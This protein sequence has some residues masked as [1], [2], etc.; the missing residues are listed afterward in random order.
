MSTPIFQDGYP[1]SNILPISLKYLSKGDFV[2]K[3][4]PFYTLKSLNLYLSIMKTYSIETTC[5]RGIEEIRRSDAELNN[6]K[7]DP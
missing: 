4:F 6:E 1:K 2:P 7:P 3:S 5:H